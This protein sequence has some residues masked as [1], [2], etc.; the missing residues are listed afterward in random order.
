MNAE[1]IKNIGIGLGFLLLQLVIFR[2]LK[3]FQVQPDLVLIFLIWY[4]AF[5]DRT[6]ALLMAA[7]FGF[8][9]DAM[10]DLWGLN[11]F[12][13]TLLIFM[14]YNFIPRGKKRLLVGQVFLTIF[15]VCL[16]HNLIFLGLNAAIQN[17]SG[18]IFFWRNLFGNSL[19]TAVVASFIQ[20]FR[21][22]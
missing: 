5:K 1:S 9:Q 18:E 12:A 21:T 19:Y 22:K 2:H 8:L 11:M 14:S 4:M 3:I 6:S 17:Y 15:V 10:L 16:L 20:L 7:S 13:K